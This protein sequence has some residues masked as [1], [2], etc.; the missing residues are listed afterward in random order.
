MSDGNNYTLNILPSGDA[1]NAS[2][3]AVNPSLDGTLQ[4]SFFL[5]NKRMNFVLTQPKIGA[6]A[7]VRSN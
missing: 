6:S 4:F 1:L 5:D 3:G 2:L 7:A